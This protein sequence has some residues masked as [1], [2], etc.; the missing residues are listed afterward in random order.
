MALG[1][2]IC[3]SGIT[4]ESL[5]LRGILI[6]LSDDYS[7]PAKTPFN[8]AIN[9]ANT[10]YYCKVENSS[11]CRNQASWASR[12]KPGCPSLRHGR[13][14][15]A[16]IWNVWKSAGINNFFDLNQ[17]RSH[18]QLNLHG[19]GRMPVWSITLRHLGFQQSWFQIEGGILFSI[20]LI[21]N[22]QDLWKSNLPHFT[23]VSVFGS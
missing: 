16:C 23:T 13:L 20:D 9:D 12:S 8:V 7:A 11:A 21:V 14:L 17:I 19:T 10:I 15:G 6:K 3:T 22:H 18:W 4:K 1:A 2:C 5:L